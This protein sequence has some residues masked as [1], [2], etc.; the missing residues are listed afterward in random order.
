MNRIGL[1]LLI[2]LTTGGAYAQGT[3]GGVTMS[4]DPARAAA[5]ESRAQELKARQA[6]ETTSKPAAT[7]KSNAKTKTKGK[8]P[9]THKSSTAKPA[10]SSKS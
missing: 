4:T 1:I 10:K 2:S 9:A 5:V 7:H 6:T 8:A 3:S